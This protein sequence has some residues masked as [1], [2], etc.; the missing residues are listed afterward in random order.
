MIVRQ[1]M[2]I[3]QSDEREFA[4]LKVNL[5]ASLIEWRADLFAQVSPLTAELNRLRN[6]L[7]LLPM[8]IKSDLAEIASGGDTSG[9]W[10]GEL[11]KHR[12]ELEHAKKRVPLLEAEL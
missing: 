11:A 7:R 12:A 8:T 6:D 10:A 4:E 2:A 5:F 1:H 9:T 3:C